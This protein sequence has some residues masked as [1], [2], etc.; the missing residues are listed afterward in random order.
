M[1]R[2]L[3]ILVV[4]GS[5]VS[6]SLIRVALA[7]QA[8]STRIEVTTAAN[9]VEALDQLGREKF[10]LVTSSLQLPDMYGLDL[11]RALRSQPSYRHTPF[12][13]VTAEPYDR[14]MRDGFRAGVNDYYDKTRGMDEFLAFVSGLVER[15]ANLSGKVMYVA[16][17]TPEAMMLAQ[18]MEAHGLNVE[19]VANAEQALQQVDASFD[20][21]VTEY[22]LSGSF[23]GGDFLYALRCGKRLNDEELPVLVITGSDD[24]VVQSD[25]FHSGGNDFVVKPVVEEVLVSRLRT[26]LLTRRRVSLLRRQS[27]EMRRMASMDILTGVYNRRYLVDRAKRFL[28]SPENRPAWV[29]MLDLDHFKSINDQHGHVT[30]DRVLTAVGA[31]FRGFFREGDVIAR[32]GG[33]EFVLL[34]RQ[35]T[36][37][38]CLAEM[39]VLRQRLEDLRPE[40]LTL[41][42]SI[43]FAASGSEADFELTLEQADRAMYRAKTLGR[44]RVVPAGTWTRQTEAR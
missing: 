37:E 40:G 6:R 19:H 39:E 26:L 29:V 16:S 4:D 22:A 28:A 9:A 42:A 41:T 8:A 21:V 30:G 17:H 7:A 14:H 35:R 20:M 18:M 27:E 5:R 32:S 33:E 11:C 24:P 43:G 38:D 15:Y 23:S 36:A 10:D 13:V 44:N 3:K 2:G 12:V 34:L 25:I 1:E 31:L